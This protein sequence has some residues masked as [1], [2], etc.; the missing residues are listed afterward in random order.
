MRSIATAA[1]IGMSLGFGSVSYADTLLGI[2]VGGGSI[3]YDLSGDFTDLEGGSSSIDFDDDLGLEGA[4]LRGFGL[5]GHGFEV[6][7]ERRSI[8]RP[9]AKTS[10]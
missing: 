4:R 1:L 5:G 7:A 10:E 6:A 8:T 9:P 2:Y 3:S